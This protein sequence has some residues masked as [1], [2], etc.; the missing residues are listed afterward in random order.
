MQDNCVCLS[1]FSQLKEEDYDSEILDL[2]LEK[3]LVGR[4]ASTPLYGPLCER[5]LSTPETSQVNDIAR[6]LV[7]HGHRSEAGHLLQLTS[8]LPR[9]LLNLSSSLYFA[10][11]KL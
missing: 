5:I 8:G 7:H 1:F 10:R 3:G 4:F 2:I 11:K 6:Q 9:Y